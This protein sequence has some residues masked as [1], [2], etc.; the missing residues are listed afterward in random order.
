MIEALEKILME[1]NLRKRLIT[2]MGWCC[3]GK[4]GKE[5]IDHLLIQHEAVMEL[6]FDLSSFGYNW[7]MPQLCGGDAGLLEKPFGE[8]Q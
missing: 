6:H 5:S 8:P 3:M 4:Q 2:I 7:I 1:D